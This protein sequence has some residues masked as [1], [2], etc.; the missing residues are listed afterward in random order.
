MPVYAVEKLRKEMLWVKNSCQD[1]RT[2]KCI[3]WEGCGKP[4]ENVMKS[5]IWGHKQ[6]F[7]QRDAKNKSCMW[8]VGARHASPLQSGSPQERG[9]DTQNTHGVGTV[10]EPPLQGFPVFRP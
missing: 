8:T 3:V 7:H 1:G 9:E 10:R 2:S 6:C 4:V 5:G